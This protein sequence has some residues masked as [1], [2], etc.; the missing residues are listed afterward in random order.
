MRD[1]THYSNFRSLELF[2]DIPFPFLKL[3]EI[4]DC[5]FA[6]IG[7]GM[8]RIVNILLE[9]KTRPLI[10][11]EPSGAFEVLYQNVR[12]LE[13]MTF[14]T[15]KALRPGGHFLIWLYGK[16]PSLSMGQFAWAIIFSSSKSAVK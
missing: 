12:K 1:T 3:E 11:L 5:R 14:L 16:Y 2:T 15:F 8:G 10:A 4:K 9:A 6:D 13:R 7:N